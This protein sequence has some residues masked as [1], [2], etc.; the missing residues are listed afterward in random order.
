VVN[1]DIPEKNIYIQKRRACVEKVEIVR[2]G[3]SSHSNAST[4][5]SCY[6][7]LVIHLGCSTLYDRVAVLVSEVSMLTYERYV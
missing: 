7:A 6:I 2:H 3:P 4:P 1:R 5:A